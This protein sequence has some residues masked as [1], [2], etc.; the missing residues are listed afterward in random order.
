MVRANTNGEEARLVAEKI[1]RAVADMALQLGPDI[2][3]TSV[4]VSIGGV[5]FPDDTGDARQLLRLAD[6]ALY[7]AKRTGRD[8][9]CFV[10]DGT[11]RRTLPGHEQRPGDRSPQ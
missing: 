6:D 2:E 8:R 9:V 4:T 11:R 5:A 10:G 7:R 3:E 1:R